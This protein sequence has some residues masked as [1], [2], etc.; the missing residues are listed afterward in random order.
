MYFSDSAYWQL[1]KY[2]G[3][4]SLEPLSALASAFA[5][6]QINVKWG[7]WVDT[8]VRGNLGHYDPTY[9]EIRLHQSLGRNLDQQLPEV[10][11]HELAHAVI[12]KRGLDQEAREAQA[13]HFAQ[14]ALRLVGPGFV[15]WLLMGMSDEA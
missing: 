8:M 7:D 12:P 11:F 5:G 10:F 1:R 2:G 6:R 4:I 9:N 13:E 3:Q 14:Q 15:W